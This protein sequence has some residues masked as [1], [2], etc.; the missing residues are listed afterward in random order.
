MSNR[1]SRMRRKSSGKQIALTERDIAIFRTLA[2][3]RYLPSTYLH[4]FA[5]G[6]SET[7][8]KERLGNLFHEGFINRPSQQWEF[9]RARYLPAVH[10]NDKGAERALAEIRG[11]SPR[12]YLSAAAHRQFRHSLMIC[13]CLASIEL[14]AK[15]RASLRFISWAEI[16]ARAPAAT[17][18]SATPFRMPLQD[19]ALT[20][21]GLFGLEYRV[22]G[23]CRYRFFALEADRGT[24]PIERTKRGQTSY[25]AKL[26][27]YRQVLTGGL[28]KQYWGVTILLVLTVTTEEQ[29]LRRLVE[30]SR[31]QV[32]S[33]S[34]LF[35]VADPSALRNPMHELL[36]TPW[37]RSGYQPLSIANA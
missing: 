10:E 22:D 16:L 8:F 21:D 5:G 9:A 34:F 23:K 12:T 20:P 33:P 25:L 2:N 31:E 17:R 37:E 13:E 4:K 11:V 15:S 30:M 32:D 36:S 24:M 3:Y 1:R 29:R 19:G 18:S 6:A 14:A 28:A 35:K 26:A 7:R 27:A